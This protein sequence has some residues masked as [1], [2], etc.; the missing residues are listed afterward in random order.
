M[1]LIS[2][3]MLAAE[4]L[5]ATNGNT[6]LDCDAGVDGSRGSQRKA[7]GPCEY[8]DGSVTR[9]LDTEAGRGGDSPPFGVEWVSVSAPWSALSD[10]E[11]GR[12]MGTDPPQA[13]T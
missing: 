5:P 9:D 1:S 12:S 6:I 10:G 3:F 7:T 8:V 2:R 11:G 4:V 13:K